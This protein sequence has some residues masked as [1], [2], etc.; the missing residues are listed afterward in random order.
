MEQEFRVPVPLYYCKACGLSQHI[1]P[2]QV[3]CFPSTP[4]SALHLT[5]VNVEKKET[6]VWLDQELLSHL[7]TSRFV[8]RRLSLEKYLKAVSIEHKAYGCPPIMSWSH[9]LPSTCVGLSLL[10][11]FLKSEPLFLESATPIYYGKNAGNV[12]AV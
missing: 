9:L 12:G 6:P 1:H 4:V 10:V 7:R 2:Y 3:N 8:A 5:R 11:L